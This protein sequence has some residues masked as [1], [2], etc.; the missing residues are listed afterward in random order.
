MM[1]DDGPMVVI[2]TSPANSGTF[3]EAQAGPSGPTTVVRWQLVR[4]D[5]RGH[6][7]TVRGCRAVASY[8]L[9]LGALGWGSVA[10]CAPHIELPLQEH[11]SQ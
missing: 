8:W 10:S 6:I 3:A 11:D 1:T 4:D 9:S 7:C 5:M 2:G